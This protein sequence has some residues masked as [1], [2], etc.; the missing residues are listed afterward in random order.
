[1]QAK[2]YP[3]DRLLARTILKSIPREVTPNHITIL[4]ICLTPLVVWLLYLKEYSFGLPIFLLVAFTDM[5][6]GSLA[7][8]RGQVT[9][10]GMLWD[11][12]ADK[13]LIGSV[14][15]LLLSRH[16]PPELAVLIIGLEVLFLLGGWYRKRQGTIV[17]ANWWGKSKMLCQVFGIAAFLVFLQSGEASAAVVSYVLF[18]LAAL[19]AVFSLLKH[20]L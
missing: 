4:R 15:I 14:A 18:L 5:I 11:P 1:M 19:L 13:L 20:G 12:I 6:D 2:T 10:W 16:F 7:R 9:A 8:V 3:H 17:A